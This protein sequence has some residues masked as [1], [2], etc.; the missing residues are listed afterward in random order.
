MSQASFYA[1]RQ[2]LRGEVP[3]AEVKLPSV[4]MLKSAGV[5]A[6][7]EGGIELR[8]PGR[9]SIVVQR[10]FDRQTL[11]E[12]LSSIFRHDIQPGQ[13]DVM[14]RLYPHLDGPVRSQV[15]DRPAVVSF[16]VGQ[17]NAGPVSRG[18]SA[19]FSRLKV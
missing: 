5:A 19:S 12:L 3:F 1:R 9:R 7:D 8:L 15:L 4:T 6:T 13:L 18:C 11:L 17:R 2:K 10:G 16:G 14:G